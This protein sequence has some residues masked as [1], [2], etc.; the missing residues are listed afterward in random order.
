L[1][2]ILAGGDS[3]QP[4]EKTKC[5]LGLG[6]NAK[7]GETMGQKKNETGLGKK[8]GGRGAAQKLCLGGAGGNDFRRGGIEK[9]EIFVGK[10]CVVLFEKKKTAA[11][12]GGGRHGGRGPRGAE[13]EG[14]VVDWMRKGKKP[15]KKKFFR[16]LRGRG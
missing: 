15:P 13:K 7:G 4:K 6:N 12:P 5:G 8:T 9:L 14:R 2:K 16:G 11:G 3:A 10:V 1:G